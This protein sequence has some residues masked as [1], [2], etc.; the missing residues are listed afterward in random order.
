MLG[1]LP[2]IIEADSSIEQLDNNLRSLLGQKAAEFNLLASLVTRYIEQ[3]R[4][5]Y[6]TVFD[7]KQG[8]EE[9]E[10]CNIKEAFHAVRPSRHIFQAFLEAAE[11]EEN[12][13]EKGRK[14]QGHIL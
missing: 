12:F 2:T 8:K 10:V 5:H 14:N 1:R 9:L 11:F 13:F 6:A 4:A 3:L 7:Q